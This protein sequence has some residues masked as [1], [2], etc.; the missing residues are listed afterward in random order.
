MSAAMARDPIGDSACPSM[1]AQGRVPSRHGHSDRGQE[2]SAQ[3]QKL[4]QTMRNGYRSKRAAFP[5]ITQ[6]ASRTP[7]RGTAFETL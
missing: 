1:R 2:P 4:K 7:T 6:R 3:N 5:A